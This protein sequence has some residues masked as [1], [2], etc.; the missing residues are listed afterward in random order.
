MTIFV[1]AAVFFVSPILA[2]SDQDTASVAIANAEETVVLTYEAVLEAEQAE[3]NVTG[4]LAQLNEA[5][6]FLA[7]ARMLYSNGDFD[8]AVYFAD[9]SRSIGE[10]VENEAY[11]LKDLASDEGVQRVWFTMLGSISGIILVVLGSLRVWWFLKRRY[12]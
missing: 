10:E 3:G 5:G 12:Q 2:S 6:E 9:L 1:F 7:A 8:N 4:L 11:E